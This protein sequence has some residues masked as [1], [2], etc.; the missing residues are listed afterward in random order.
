MFLDIVGAR[1]ARRN[2]DSQLMQDNYFYHSIIVFACQNAIQ[3]NCYAI[4]KLV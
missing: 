3:S 4:Y 1:A 2:T